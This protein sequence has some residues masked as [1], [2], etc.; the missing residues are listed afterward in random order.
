[1][2]IMRAVLAGVLLF[3]AASLP[4]S[5]AQPANQEL[6]KLYGIVST[7]A[8][9]K[10]YEVDK[11]TDKFWLHPYLQVATAE[12]PAYLDPEKDPYNWVIGFDGAVR[13][14]EETRNPYGRKYEKS[15]IRP[16]DNSK[17]KPG[18]SEKDGHVTVLGGEGGRI[19]GEF[20]Y[21]KKNNT[22]TI[23]NKSGRYSNHNPDRT[24]EQLK[25]A[26]ALIKK[27]VNPGSAPW[28][29]T[30]YLMRYAPKDIRAKLLADPNLK[31]RNPDKKELIEKDPYIVVTE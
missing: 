4:A 18:W 13:I 28:G 15:V 23:N 12:H 16:E 6:D 11:K 8:Y 5:A 9:V 1:M 25:N 29:E 3:A 27:V 26:V 20:L 30:Q 7:P 14:N 21:N 22:W 17:R 10:H 19:G 2:K 31:F 24:V